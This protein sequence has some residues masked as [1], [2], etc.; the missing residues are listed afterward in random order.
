MT[1]SERSYTPDWKQA[2]EILEEMNPGGLPLWGFADFNAAL[3]R[4][5]SPALSDRERERDADQGDVGRPGEEAAERPGDHVHPV[6]GAELAQ[7]GDHK[8]DDGN[9]HQDSHTLSLP[10]GVR[11]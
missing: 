10:G 7:E 6:E 1:P 2:R 4:G 11:S 3:L 5:R 8:A 9:Q